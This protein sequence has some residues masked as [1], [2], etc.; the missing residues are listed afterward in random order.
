[1][2]DIN[3]N[4]TIGLLDFLEKK[5]DF[6][7]HKCSKSNVDPEILLLINDLCCVAAHTSA[8]YE[9]SDIFE[10]IVEAA[11]ELDKEDDNK[12]KK[13]ANLLDDILSYKTILFSKASR[14]DE[15]ERLQ[16]EY[17]SKEREHDYR[18]A[19]EELDK[20]N[21]SEQTEKAFKDQVKQY[22]PLESSLS[23][24]YD[25]EYPGVMLIRIS[26]NVYQSSMTGKVYDYYNGYTT[27]KGNKIPGSSV[28]RQI[29]DWNGAPSG[30]M[31]DTRDGRISRY[32]SNKHYT[33]L[34]EYLKTVSDK[35]AAS[36]YSKFVNEL[37]SRSDVNNL[38]MS[39][40]KELFSK[41]L[42]SLHKKFDKLGIYSSLESIEK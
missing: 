23:T 29:P 26:D 18:Y 28:D 10:K 38:E 2:S 17:S 19:K 4:I 5:A 42:K 12:F 14:S 8:L 7:F 32:A 16:K 36:D 33:S 35:D 40:L 39:D 34:E 31:F 24:R 21:K 37:F 30:F 6:I 27:N 11:N 13:V 9:K 1:M 22:R 15:L 25:P 3:E 20:M 41:Y